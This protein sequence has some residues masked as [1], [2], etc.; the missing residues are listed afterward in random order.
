MTTALYLLRAKQLNLSLDDLAFLEQWQVI[1]MIIESGND[2]YDYPIKGTKKD[3][4]RLF[5]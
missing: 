4:E 1:D 3:F 5:G 2:H